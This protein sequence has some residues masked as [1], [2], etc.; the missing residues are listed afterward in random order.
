MYDLKR[1]RKT[2]IFSPNNFRP[3]IEIN[4]LT[5][6][7]LTLIKQKNTGTFK[8][9]SDLIL[10]LSSFIVLRK[11]SNKLYIFRYITKLFT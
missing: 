11:F 9:Y 8:F 1:R 4:D 2:K 5:Q 6:I 7:I 10:G 3:Y